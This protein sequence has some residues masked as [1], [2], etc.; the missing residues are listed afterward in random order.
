MRIR[1]NLPEG[2]VTAED[3]REVL[4]F[5][6]TLVGLEL[7]GAQVKDLFSHGAA[8]VGEGAM[9]QVS[10]EVQVTLQPGS[11]PAFSDL[12]INGA[13]VQ[14]DQTYRVVTNSYLADGGDEYASF[15]E[16]T[17]FY[18]SRDYYSVVFMEYLRDGCGGT[19]TLETD[20]RLLVP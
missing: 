18:E 15:P 8:S 17:W 12:T 20:G 13:A 6:N 11:D 10:Q 9:P 7:T 16:G 4:P 19:L 2:D 1:A 14:D 3:V 5:E